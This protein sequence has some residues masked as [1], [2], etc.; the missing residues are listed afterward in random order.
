M[1]SRVQK[2]NETQIDKD[3]TF[4][5][6]VEWLGTPKDL[7]RAYI[8]NSIV[9]K[10]KNMFQKVCELIGFYSVAGLTGVSILPVTSILSVTFYACAALVPIAGIVKWV[11][12]LCGID[13]PL[14]MFQIGTFIATPFQVFLIS[15]V[16]EVPFWL[17]GKAFWKMTTAYIKAVIS[18]RQKLNNRG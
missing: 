18:S 15:L 1:H 4:D 6:V 9:Y 8:G 17:L 13:V 12:S 16:L 10:K 14:I 3:I 7:A 11:L 5:K 2:Y